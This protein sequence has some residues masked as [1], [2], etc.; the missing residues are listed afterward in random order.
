MQ[1]GYHQPLATTVFG[2]GTPFRADD[3]FGYCF[4]S[5]SDFTTPSE[6]QLY[7]LGIFFRDPL[8]HQPMRLRFLAH[9]LANPAQVTME[10]FRSNG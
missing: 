3:S 5:N 6:H 1:A 4:L 9:S 2:Q 8:S 7:G 10:E